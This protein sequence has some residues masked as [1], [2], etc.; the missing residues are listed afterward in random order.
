MRRGAL[1]AL[2][3]TLPHPSHPFAPLQ[4]CSKLV[5]MQT[6]ARPPFVLLAVV[7]SATTALA[8][9]PQGSALDA[10]KTK[11]EQSNFQETSRY[12]EVVDFMNAVAKAAPK[13]VFLTTFG[14]TNEKRALPLAVVGA[15]AATPQ[16][17]RATNKIRVYIQGNIHGGEVEGK[18]SAQMLLRELAQGK[19][20]DWL[21][22]MVFLIAPIYNADGKERFAL[23]NRD[24]QCLEFYLIEPRSDDG[25]VDWNLLDEALRDAK[26]DPILR[27]RN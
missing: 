18:E 26:V 9:P 7:L 11:P 15:S 8:Q 20:E 10:L 24:P 27:T 5:R 23:N 13:K 22:T 4:F 12:Q 1:R 21:K 3:R 16:A 2:S 17:V 6:C 25:L 19:H 14:E